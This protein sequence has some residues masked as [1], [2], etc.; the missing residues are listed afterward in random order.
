[1]PLVYIC[2]LISFVDFYSDP[3]YIGFGYI[4]RLMTLIGKY[5]MIKPQTNEW[6][7]NCT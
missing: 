4:F 5:Q 6:S 2:S 7:K 1:M 3:Y